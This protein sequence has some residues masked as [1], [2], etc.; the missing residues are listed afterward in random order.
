[1]SENKH[2]PGPWYW[3]DGAIR[4]ANRDFV[5]WPQNVMGALELNWADCLGAC[6]K[7]SE[8]NAE[9]NARLIAAAP[10]LLEAL[11]RMLL[12]FDFLIEEGKLPD[13]RND[14]IFDHARTAIAKATGHA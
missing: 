11:Q 8:D 12:E 3:K 4:A 14:V 9:A 13:I 7:H 2:T 5:L 1:M 10:E 6:G